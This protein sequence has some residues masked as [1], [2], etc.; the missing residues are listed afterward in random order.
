MTLVLLILLLVGVALMAYGPTRRH[1]LMRPL[2]RYFQRSMPPLSATERE[3]IAAGDTWWEAQ[4]FR[5]NPDWQHLHQ[6]PRPQLSAAEQAFVDTQVAQLLLLLD[7]HQIVSELQDL[8]TEV[9]QFL[10]KERFFALNISPEYGGLGFSAL[11]NSTIVARI[12]SK[13]LSAAVTVMVPNSLGPAELLSHYG[14]D[15][16]KAKWL[17]AL[18]AGDELPCFALTGPEAGSDAGAIPDEG[19][20]CHGEHEGAPC[21]GIRL[22]W[23]KRYITLA[24]V[25]TVLGLAFKLRD[26]DALLG[27]VVE[28][29]ITCALIPAHHPGVSI[30]AR[31]NPLHQAFM[32][33]TTD[34]LD[35]FIPLEWIIGGPDYAGKGWR[36]LVECLSAG[37]G[38]SLPALATAASQIAARSSGA[39]AY[40]RRQFGLPLGKFE[41]VQLPLAE[42]GANAYRLEAMRVLTTTAIDLGHKPAVLT[43]IAKY[44]MT[45][46][47]RRSLNH[48]MDIHGGRGIQCGPS[49]YLAHQYMGIPIAI[50]VEGA[51][52]LTRNLMIFGQGASRCHP[53]IL[54]EMAAAADSD[55]ERGLLE[56][57]RLLL[58]HLGYSLGNGW[59]ALWLGWSGCRFSRAP[60]TG[61]TARYYG[62]LTR[63]S[64]LLAVLAD[65]AMLVLGGKLKRKEALSARLG[66]LLS[67]LYMASAVVKRFE[68]D[69]RR[70]ADLP[71]LHYCLQE[72]LQQ[73][74][75]ALS[76]FFDNFAPR[77][78]GRMLRVLFMPWG[79]H[80]SRPTD[81]L[82]ASVAEAMMR[83]DQHRLRLSP[84]CYV[85]AAE[86]GDALAI[87][88]R[89]FVAMAATAPLQQRLKQAQLSG[90][91]AA[92]QSLTALWQQA[93]AQQLLTDAELAALEQCEQWRQQAIAVDSFAAGQRL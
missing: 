62:Q 16:Q 77:W 53:F 3:A 31:H 72:S 39:Y 4:L 27:D 63:M 2:Y 5:G 92:Q 66:D 86:Q 89:A 8:P 90:Q 45:E 17:P 85:G 10:K 59:R 67:H 69:G 61:E 25:A 83:S 51:N 12:A 18:A 20:I 81:A 56:F 76:G 80:F 11:A 42:I 33:G 68:A 15:A 54:A 55:H 93:K 79:C 82:S 41:G 71:Y 87:L 57:D 40:V 26:P 60:V 38:I 70:S 24:P 36:M 9:W 21:L 43:A 44:Q 84:L 88:E 30:G 29:G 46:L 23:H 75:E 37:R 47:A 48:A 7:D 28:L 22:N 50:T 74:G 65:V 13:S 6:L 35:V 58:G 32:N 19:I 64:A 1:L 52:I 49:N 34:G 91:L 73:M 14:T 78:L